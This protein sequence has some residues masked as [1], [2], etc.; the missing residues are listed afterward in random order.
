MTSFQDRVRMEI[1]DGVADVRLVRGEKHNG[2]DWPMFVALN[3]AVD[4]VVEAGEDVN[5]IV[6]SGDGPSFCAGLDFKSFAEGNGDF[7]GDGFARR[8]GED[9]N[10]AQRVTY[11]WRALEVPVIAALRGAC[12]GGG[13]QLALAADVRI[14]EPSTRM[15]VMEI[16]Y[17]LVPDMGLSQTIVPLVRPDVARELAYTAR[18]VEADE[19]LAIGLVTRLADDADGAARELAA[20]IAEKSPAAIRATKRLAAEAWGKPPAEGLALEAE[21]QK[22]LIGTPGQIAAVQKTMSGG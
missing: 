18:I 10:F 13:L 5:V 17:G 2:L 19:A 7:A 14:A 3:E 11:G 8:D 1:S 20:E 4:A 6:L 22:T 12:F 16:R 21:L 15:S 9:A